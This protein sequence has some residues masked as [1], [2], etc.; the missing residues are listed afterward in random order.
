MIPLQ[1]RGVR[2]QFIY[3][4]KS[5]LTHDLLQ[6]RA[7]HYNKFTRTLYYNKGHLITMIKSL[8]T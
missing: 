6:E 8:G 5:P 3:Y 7:S 2:L 4:K 1:E